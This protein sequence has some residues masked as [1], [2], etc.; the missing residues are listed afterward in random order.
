MIRNTRCFHTISCCQY[1]AANLFYVLVTMREIVPVIN[2]TGN[3]LRRTNRK[4]K[5]KLCFIVLKIEITVMVTQMNIKIEI[6][7]MVTQMN[8]KNEII[9]YR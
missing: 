5:E 8:I 6:T 9:Y 1:P 2:A 7:V 4:K 3:Q